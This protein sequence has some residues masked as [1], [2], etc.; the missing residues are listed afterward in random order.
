MVR[1]VSL[2]ELVEQK[3]LKNKIKNIGKELDKLNNK[4][5]I[6]EN[7]VYDRSAKLLTDNL[8]KFSRIVDK[9]FESLPDKN[10]LDNYKNN[11]YNNLYAKLHSE[12][13]NTIS[14]KHAPVTREYVEQLA[15]RIS[16]IEG[17]I[18]KMRELLKG[19]SVRVPVI[20]E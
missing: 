5:N 11:L 13:M 9:K 6:I 18:S 14:K 15:K 7:S 1:K 10:F 20:V 12:I 3:D 16:I 2:N 17:Q 4:I 19:V 8:R